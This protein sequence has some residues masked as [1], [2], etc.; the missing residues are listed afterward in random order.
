MGGGGVMWART[1]CN[2]FF[3]G[4]C[5]CVC[6]TVCVLLYKFVTPYDVLSRV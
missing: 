5:V 6:L 1:S 3:F 4:V 2:Y